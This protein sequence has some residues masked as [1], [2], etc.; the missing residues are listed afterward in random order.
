M[1]AAGSAAVHPGSRPAAD[2]E[3]SDALRA[4]AFPG[5]GPPAFSRQLGALVDASEQPNISIRVVLFDADTIPLP[6]ENFTYFEGPVQELDTVQADSGV[7]N[8]IF[9]AP[10]NTARFR[11]L[12]TRIGLA[13]LSEQESR[14]YIRSIKKNMESKYA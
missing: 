12:I 4:L 8:L 1:V 7:G 9:D 2:P 10:A 3:P 14:E 5:E 11:S 13:A 6:N